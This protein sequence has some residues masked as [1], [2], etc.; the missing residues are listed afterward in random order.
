MNA[1]IVLWVYILLLEAGGLMGFLKARSKASLIASS[2]FAAPLLLCA[3]KVL[4]LVAALWIIGFL[5]VFFGGRFARSKK[6]M[7]NGVMAIASLVAVV[8][9]YLSTRSGS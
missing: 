4:P 5:V 8:L 3:L 2:L 1:Y 7:P 9:L 6:L